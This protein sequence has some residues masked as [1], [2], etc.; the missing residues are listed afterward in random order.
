MAVT[1]LVSDGIHLDLSN[2]RK[3]EKTNQEV[4]RILNKVINLNF[5]NI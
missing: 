4:A 5:K 1:S 2:F 3:Y